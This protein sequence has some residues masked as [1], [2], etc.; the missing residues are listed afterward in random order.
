MHEQSHTKVSKYRTIISVLFS[1]SYV[2]QNQE[3]TKH[4]FH[5]L[6]LSNKDKM[7][8]EELQTLLVLAVL[9]RVKRGILGSM[10]MFLLSESVQSLLCFHLCFQKES[11]TPFYCSRV[12]YQFVDTKVKIRDLLVSNLQCFDVFAFPYFTNKMFLSLHMFSVK[13]VS[14]KL[15]HL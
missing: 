2:I 14:N 13:A 9:D 3:K 15:C 10:K 12:L 5:N 4:I 6:R 11:W 7:V 1:V 8:F